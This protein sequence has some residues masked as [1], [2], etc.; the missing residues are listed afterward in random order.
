MFGEALH[1]SYMEYVMVDIP[2]FYAWALW[3]GKLC[4]SLHGHGPSFLWGRQ[5]LCDMNV[6]SICS[7]N[8]STT[9]L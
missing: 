9:F 7:L 2:K 3:N 6:M 8:R 5:S 1:D 4:S